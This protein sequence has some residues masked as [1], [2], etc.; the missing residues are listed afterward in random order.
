[1]ITARLSN[2]KETL[3]QKTEEIAV[4]K[5][6]SILFRGY[7]ASVNTRRVNSRVSYANPRPSRGFA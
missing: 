6:W 5:Q 4:I 1:M 3:E 7:V 2:K